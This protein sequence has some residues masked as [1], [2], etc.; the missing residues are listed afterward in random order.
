MAGFQLSINGRFWVSTE[1]YESGC[2][3][4]GYQS[5]RPDACR[6]IPKMLP[7]KQAVH[8]GGRSRFLTLREL[9]RWHHTTRHE[10]GARPISNSAGDI[11]GQMGQSAVEQQRTSWNGVVH[12]LLR[13]TPAKLTAF[14]GVG[15][16]LMAEDTV[17]LQTH[18]D[19]SVPSNLAVCRDYRSERSVGTAGRAS[20]A[21]RY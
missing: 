15:A 16:G 5:R 7:L 8:S 17:Y 19:C 2:T 18:S 10:S 12:L 11:I 21:W 6:R 13:T 4:P 1:G 9:A 14:G 20:R 3:A